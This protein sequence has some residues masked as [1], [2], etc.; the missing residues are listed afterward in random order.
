VCENSV[1]T[2]SEV[3][4]LLWNTNEEELLS[5]HGYDEYQLTLWKYPSM[6]KLAKLIGHSSSVHYMAQVP[7]PLCNWF[8]YREC[9]WLCC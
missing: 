8:L 4:A 2:G 6:K 5:S 7:I 9:L 3:C 1:D